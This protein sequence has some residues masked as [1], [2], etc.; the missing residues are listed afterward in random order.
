MS[1]LP[2]WPAQNHTAS[3]FLRNTVPVCCAANTDHNAYLIVG[4][5]STWFSTQN[6]PETLHLVSRTVSGST[7][8]LTALATSPSC[9][10]GGVPQ[11]R[12]WIQRNG[13]KGGGREERRE[14]K[15]EGAIPSVLFSHFLAETEIGI[16][17]CLYRCSL[18][19][20]VEYQISLELHCHHLSCL[21]FVQLITK[22]ITSVLS[23]TCFKPA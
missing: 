3:S 23:E 9:I 20:S 4:A 14:R 18:D 17:F 8:K 5:G 16:V 2:L 6:V 12:E 10:W 21:R 1:A 11:D 22:S 19:Y 15:R 7:G 13:R